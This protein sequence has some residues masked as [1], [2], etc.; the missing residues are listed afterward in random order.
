MSWNIFK[1]RVD[2]NMEN[3]LTKEEKELIK[4][5]VKNAEKN[6]SGEI[7]VAVIGGCHINHLNR[8]VEEF[9]KMGITATRDHTGVLISIFVDE[10][11]VIVLADEAI[12]EKVPTGTWDDVIKVIV[13]S[14][15]DPKQ[16]NSNGIVKAVELAGKHLSEHFPH[17]ADDTNEL[18][19]DIAV[20]EK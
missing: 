16:L 17:K 4:E 9:S 2:Y 19:D 8:A 18:P 7:R 11:K 14:I 20:S 6:T 13:E 3:F 12:N 15:K 1:K 10:R 5:S